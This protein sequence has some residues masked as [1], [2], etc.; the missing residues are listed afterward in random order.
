LFLDIGQELGEFLRVLTPMTLAMDGRHNVPR[1]RPKNWEFG[2]SGENTQHLCARGESEVEKS[3]LSRDSTGFTLVGA[4]IEI[5][6]SWR[7][8]LLHLVA[9]IISVYFIRREV[10]RFFN[11]QM[12]DKSAPLQMHLRL[13]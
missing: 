11:N 12:Q 7:S 13:Y 6:I 3:H 1:S 8:P 10:N 2:D 9:I 4:E 5:R